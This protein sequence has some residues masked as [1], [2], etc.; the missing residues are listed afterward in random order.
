[1][2]VIT[3]IGS[4]FTS[5]TGKFAKKSV[6]HKFLLSFHLINIWIKMFLIFRLLEACLLR[7]QDRIA[8]IQL[9]RPKIMLLNIQPLT[10]ASAV[11]ASRS[12]F[13]QDSNHCS[14]CRRQS[15]SGAA[16]RSIPANRQEVAIDNLNTH[17]HIFC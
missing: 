1:M 14:F 11:K 16:R 5:K 12:N 9:V 17:L 3:K 7:Q 10:K 4:F 15:L 6:K 13:Q 8:Y 2:L